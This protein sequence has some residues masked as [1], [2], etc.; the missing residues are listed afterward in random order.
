MG[1]VAC[2]RVCPFQPG[3]PQVERWPSSGVE[4]TGP[5]GQ[6]GQVVVPQ[7]GGWPTV[8]ATL[9]AS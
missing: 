5:D 2:H 6:G 8:A 4:L 7:V 1:R 3:I 9:L